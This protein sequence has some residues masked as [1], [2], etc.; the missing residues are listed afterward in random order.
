MRGLAGVPAYGWLEEN[1]VLREFL[2]SGAGVDLVL[3]QMS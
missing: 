2:A 1:E 3:F